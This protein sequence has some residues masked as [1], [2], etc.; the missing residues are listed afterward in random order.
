MILR[1]SGQFWQFILH[2]LPIDDERNM[3]TLDDTVPSMN[4]DVAILIFSLLP[5]KCL[6]AAS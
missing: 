1:Y 4:V 3:K 5:I 6:K 2:E